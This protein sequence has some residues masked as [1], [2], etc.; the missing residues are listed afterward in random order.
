MKKIVRLTES[1]LIKLV[2]RV[3]NESKDEKFKL[4][5]MY[6]F[7]AEN[8][9]S[10]ESATS[11]PNHKDERHHLRE[12]K[13]DLE[14]EEWNSNN[15]IIIFKYD[16][17]VYVAPDCTNDMATDYLKKHFGHRNERISVPSYLA[18]SD[19]WYSKDAFLRFKQPCR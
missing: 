12:F 1:D 11:H 18:Q 6:D 15:G 7:G 9:K 19:S 16:D 4:D 5:F 13:K 8:I 14:N 2:K 3:I 17:E 10:I